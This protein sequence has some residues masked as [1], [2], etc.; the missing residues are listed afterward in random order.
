MRVGSVALFEPG[1]RVKLAYETRDDL[2]EIIP[3]GS[4]G[5]IVELSEEDEEDGSFDLY[6]VSFDHQGPDSLPVWVFGLRLLPEDYDG[7]IDDN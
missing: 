6:A 5:I 7:I 1:D 4:E 2:G 3:G